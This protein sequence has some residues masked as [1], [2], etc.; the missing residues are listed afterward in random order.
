MPVIIMMFSYTTILRVAY[1]KGRAIHIG[2]IGQTMDSAG[3]HRSSISSQGNQG[4]IISSTSTETFTSRQILASR[5]SLLSLAS[6]SQ[7]KGVIIIC[8]ILGTLLFSWLP[9]MAAIMWTL[10]GMDAPAWFQCFSVSAAFTCSVTYP[11]VYGL[12]NRSIRNDMF[13]MLRLPQ[14]RPL[15][16]SVSKKILLWDRSEGI[17]LHRTNSSI[18]LTKVTVN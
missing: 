18:Y 16:G 9:Y 6:G 17:N 4:V 13:T 5:P 1:D 2:T 15:I 7:I 8:I 10:T 14:Q 11:V 12:L 3:S